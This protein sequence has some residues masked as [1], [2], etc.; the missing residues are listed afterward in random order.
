MPRSRSPRAH[1]QVL[2]AALKLFAHQGVEATS[3]DAI[4][5]ESGVS[6]AT[7]YKHWRDK[8]AL[9]LEAVVYLHGRDLLPMA[10]TGNIRNDLIAV[11]NQRT[12]TQHSDLQNAILP[13]LVA[14]AARKPVFAKEWRARVMQPSRIQILQLLKRAIAD[15]SLPADLNLGVALAMLLGSMMYRHMFS[16]HGRRLPENLAEL[17]VDAFWR[18]HSLPHPS[19]PQEAAQ[20]P[21]KAGA[22]SSNPV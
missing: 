1:Q 6:K 14:Y 13:H 22:I 11:L 15:G 18:A 3:M 10:M 7:I 20:T 8:D 21:V 2:E 5:A 19:L 9:C 4:A 16:Q 12:H 17:V